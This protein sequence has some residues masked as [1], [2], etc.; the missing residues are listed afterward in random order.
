MIVNS[1]ISKV[2]TNFDQISL[3]F[4][5]IYVITFFSFQSIHQVSGGILLLVFIHILY[6]NHQKIKHE[7]VFFLLIACLLIQVA[8]WYNSLFVIPDYASSIPT[9]DRLAK[10][11]LF[12]PIAIL[13]KGNTRVIFSL[14]FLFFISLVLA[15]LTSPTLSLD[16][17]N[18][19][20]GKRVD[21][22]IKNE[23]YSAAFSGLCLIGFIHYL[24]ESKVRDFKKTIICVIAIIVSLLILLP[25]QSRMTYVAFLIIAIIYPLFH[26]KNTHSSSF[27]SMTLSYV[28]IAAITVLIFQ[29]PL[30]SNRFINEVSTISKVLHFDFSSIPMD[31]SGFRINSWIEA[32]SL[33]SQNPMIG[34]DKNAAFYM[35]ETSDFFQQYSDIERINGIR[36]LHSS[37]IEYLLYYGVTGFF[38]IILLYSTCFY[39]LTKYK[40][41][42]Y[43]YRYWIGACFLFL[44]YWMIINN[45]ESFNSRQYGVDTHNLILGSFF[46][47][48]WRAKHID[49][50]ATDK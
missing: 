15:A 45:F 22:G 31:S 16:V 39:S 6:I 32:I 7:P 10:L 12:I 43:N 34:I 11:F 47:L 36:H 27:Y 50:N 1:I 9:L 37:F 26:L 41:K 46:S 5:F 23:M 14:W 20:S 17:Q 42:I 44:S 35:F 3:A 40:N 29:L 18:A 2:K 13:I 30:I 24:F 21:F 49:N 25:A 4:L 38:I 28:G 33:F 8:S 19:I 48:Y